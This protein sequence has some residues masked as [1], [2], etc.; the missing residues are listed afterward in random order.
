MSRPSLSRR[1]FLL[2]LVAGS[3][4]TGGVLAALRQRK[5]NP[6]PTDNSQL[7]FQT[8]RAGRITTPSFIAVDYSRCSGCRICEAEC[9][10]L[11]QKSLDYQRSRIRLYRY[12]PAVD[13]A[14]ICAG[15]SDAPCVSVCPKE[16]GALRRD[17]MTG[18]ILLDE[19]RC[20]G[21]KACIQVCEKDRTG[22]IRLNRE[23]TKAIGLCDL[24]GGDP[25]CVKACPEQCLSVV[26]ANVDGKS[27]AAK[28]AVLAGRLTRTLYRA[29]R[30]GE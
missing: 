19:A 23:G 21:C 29:G 27:L 25:A 26:P 2:G 9:S 13:I 5:S 14:S 12:E 6:P 7:V 10:L 8:D 24:C 30:I 15:C 28:P 16:A 22:I 20:I 4:A 17:T 11:R 1:S 3:M 18:A